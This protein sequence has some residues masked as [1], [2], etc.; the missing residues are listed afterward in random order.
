MKEQ[1]N[2]AYRL[3]DI[4]T[5]SPALMI[6]GTC[7]SIFG[8]IFVAKSEVGILAIEFTGGNLQDCLQRVVDKFNPYTVKRVNEIAKEFVNAYKRQDLAYLDS[9]KLL[10]RGTDFQR[11]VWVELANIPYGNITSYKELANAIGN[12]KAV[13]AV[14][15]AVASN[16]ISIM[17]PCHRVIHADGSLSGYR[18]GSEVKQKLLDWE[19]AFMKSHA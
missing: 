16:P 1:D 14:A 3:I 4:E 8:E 15:N 18:W 12:P 13:R 10:I 6:Y 19:A 11:K 17:I 5:I 7:Q 9:L 2:S